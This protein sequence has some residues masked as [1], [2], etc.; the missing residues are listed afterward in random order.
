MEVLRECERVVLVQHDQRTYL[1]PASGVEPKEVR[2]GRKIIGP[3][4]GKVP[5]RRLRL[6]GKFLDGSPEG[7]EKSDRH[8]TIRWKAKPNPR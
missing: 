6:A 4:I 2:P 3:D 8:D 7:V 5:A 1:V